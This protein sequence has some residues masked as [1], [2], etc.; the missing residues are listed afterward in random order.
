MTNTQ[1]E[2][3]I[4]PADFSAQLSEYSM[5]LACEG[6][7]REGKAREEGARPVLEAVTVIRETQDALK[8]I[9]LKNTDEAKAALRR[10]L[11]ELDRL[12]GSHGEAALLP[13]STEV[14][15]VDNEPDQQTIEEVSG[16]VEELIAGRHYQAAR[17]LL[18]DLACEII[19]ISAYIPLATYPDIMRKALNFLNNA[20]IAEAE[21]ALMVALESL[22]IVEDDIPLPIVRAEALV[23]EVN[24]LAY[25]GGFEK[26]HVQLLIREAG[27]Q[28]GLVE[29]LGYGTRKEEFA[30]IYSALRDVQTALDQGEKSLAFLDRLRGIVKDFKE[31]VTHTT[32]RAA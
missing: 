4:I 10:T 14:H 20:R 23:E 6:I 2:Y 19:V 11:G 21:A 15:I 17:L 1:S 28:I 7:Y 22:V 30:E 12:L 27:Q 18:R 9:Q 24:R 3:N 32:P 29:N 26:A 16:L 13:I 31:R 25:E 8:F 5:R